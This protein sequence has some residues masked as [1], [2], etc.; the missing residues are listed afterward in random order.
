MR[1]LL[2][3]YFF[4]VCFVVIGRTRPELMI[5]YIR[6]SLYIKISVYDMSVIRSTRFIYLRI[7]FKVKCRV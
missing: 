5:L 6:F 7:E 2:T 1:Y 4:Y 3:F